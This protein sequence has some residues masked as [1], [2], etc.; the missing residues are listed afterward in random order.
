MSES[1]NST[2]KSTQ[3]KIDDLILLAFTDMAKKSIACISKFQCPPS[4]VADMLRDIANAL[5]SSHSESESD[6]SCC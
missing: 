5:E 3:K 1:C 6:C 2:W 4:Y